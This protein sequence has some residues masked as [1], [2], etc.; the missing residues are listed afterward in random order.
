MPAVFCGAVLAA[1]LLFLACPAH[2]AVEGSS[3][4]L[5]LPYLQLGDA[6]HGSRS[7]SM[8]VVWHTA[9][10][11]SGWRA[12]VK[13]GRLWRHAAEPVSQRIAIPGT[14]PHLVWTVRLEGL[15]PGAEFYYRV[16]RGGQ[17]VFAATGRARRSASEAYRFVVFGDCAAGTPAE[18]AIAYQAYKA[19]PDFLF[20]T[21][22]IVYSAG[23]ISE[24][25]EK[26]FPVYNAA[27]ASPETGAPLI[28]SVLF[29][30]APGNHDLAQRDLGRFPDT[31]AYF[32]YWRQPLNGPEPG[33]F[34]RL[35]GAQENQE[36]FRA[37][38]G[39]RFPRMSNF[40]FDYANAHWTVLD[41]N[42][43]LDWSSPL[44]SEWVARDLESARNATWRFVAFH[45]PGFNSSHAHFDDQQMRVLAPV[46]EKGNVDIVFA[47][48]VHNYQ[49]SLPLRFQPKA[50]DFLKSRRVDGEFT[51]DREFDGAAHTK[52]NGVLYLVTG[53]GGASLYDPPQQNQ[54]QTWQSFTA[55]FVSQVHSMT[56]AEVDGRT[57]KVRQVSDQGDTVDSF[58]VTK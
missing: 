26:F 34:S 37:G 22:D 46:F 19:Q 42:P 13:S 39:N 10:G 54:P 20:I 33:A 6:A 43:Y 35:A 8:V 5:E 7:E 41:S 15:K 31:L 57:L 56:V 17:E 12:E 14:P 11:S 4:L 25:R 2:P 40:S 21:G 48:H 23:R 53:A 51:L 28:R 52:A 47:G 45:H 36:A 9:D 18:K 3:E 44:L 58:T 38:A 24:Y 32:Y 1:T 55:K 16:L 30:A 29:L 50:W 27:T 49:R